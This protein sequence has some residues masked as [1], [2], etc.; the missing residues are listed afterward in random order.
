[1]TSKPKTQTRELGKKSAHYFI[2]L[3]HSAKAKPTTH[4]TV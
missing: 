3:N 1:M 4:T 2:T